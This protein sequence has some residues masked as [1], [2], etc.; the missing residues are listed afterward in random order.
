VA[1]GEKRLFGA[2]HDGLDDL[3]LHSRED[4]DMLSVEGDAFCSPFQQ[5]Q[6][7]QRLI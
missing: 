5:Q 7:R 6:K 2:R 1:L 4:F 3:S